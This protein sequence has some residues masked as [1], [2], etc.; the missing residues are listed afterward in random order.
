MCVVR[1]SAQDASFDMQSARPCLIFY[2][3]VII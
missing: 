2:M 3:I 1:R